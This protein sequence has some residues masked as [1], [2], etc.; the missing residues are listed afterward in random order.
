MNATRRMASIA[1]LVALC[2]ICINA[3]PLAAQDAA[4]GGAPKYTMAEYNAYQ[5]A[6]AEKNPAAQIKLLDD[7]VSKYPNSSLLNYIYPLYYKNYG[8]QKNFPKTIDYC[9]KLLALGDKASASERYDA[10]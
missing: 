6:A 9:D 4:A 8:T 1:V 3:A 10:Y 2:L 5:A 7:F